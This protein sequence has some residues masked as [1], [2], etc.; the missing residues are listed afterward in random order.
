MKSQEMVDRSEAEAAVVVAM[1]LGF[2]VGIVSGA[3]AGSLV[4]W[5]LVRIVS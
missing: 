1:R 4:T 2:V 3:V 5:L